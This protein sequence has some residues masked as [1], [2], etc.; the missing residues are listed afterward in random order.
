MCSLTSAYSP[1][2]FGSLLLNRLPCGEITGIGKVK[3]AGPAS[4]IPR[5]PPGGQ[6]LLIVVSLTEHLK[7]NTMGINDGFIDNTVC[8]YCGEGVLMRLQVKMDGVDMNDYA[9]GDRVSSQILKTIQNSEAKFVQAFCRDLNICTEA[10][11][12]IDL[13]SENGTVAIVGSAYRVGQQCSCG[14]GP[15]NVS[16]IAVVENGVFRGFADELPDESPIVTDRG[17][18]FPLWM[19]QDPTIRSHI[20]GML[21]QVFGCD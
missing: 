18:V 10:M 9:V 5:G 19:L 6:L 13:E 2:F 14:K 4:K 21:E 15:E 3:E 17:A 20:L 1:G 16:R 7:G 12:D 8:P 11:A